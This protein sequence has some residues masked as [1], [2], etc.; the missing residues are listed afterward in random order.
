MTQPAR[1]GIILAG[2]F[3]IRFADGEKLL[4]TIDG[5]PLLAR[6]IDGL[7]PAVDGVVVSCREE[8]LDDF[9]PIFDAVSVPVTPAPDPVPDRGPAAG[10]ATALETVDAPWVA[11]VAGDM[12]FVDGVFLEWLFDRIADD[13]DDGD[14]TANGSEGAVPEFDGHRQST[15]AVYR[16][17]ALREAVEAALDGDDG[18]LQG[19]IEQLDVTVVPERTVL[20]HTSARTFRDVNTVEDID[21]VRESL[22]DAAADGR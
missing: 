3:G 20:S 17:A 1:A 8:Q 15:H 7:A 12:P 6:A 13:G 21:E 22:R 9:R 18:S 4:A 16:T 10:L 14:D 19:V 5:E 11:V 2:G